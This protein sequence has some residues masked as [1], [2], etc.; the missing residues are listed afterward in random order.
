[1]PRLNISRASG[2]TGFNY[3]V[4]TRLGFPVITERFDAIATAYETQDPAAYLPKDTHPSVIAG[5]RTFQ[6][7]HAK[8]LRKKNVRET[9]NILNLSA[10]A[11]LT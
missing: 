2:P 5:Y 7:V 1:M 8:Q 3:N 10:L 9:K 6:K 4:V 11:V